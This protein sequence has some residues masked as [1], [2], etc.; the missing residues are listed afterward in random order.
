[1]VIEARINET[2][3]LHNEDG[4][5]REAS[6][7]L[8]VAGRSCPSLYSSAMVGIEVSWTGADILQ[9]GRVGI[10]CSL[11][12]VNKT[13]H[14]VVLLCDHVSEASRP[15]PPCI[16]ISNVHLAL[17]AN[18]SHAPFSFALSCSFSSSFSLFFSLAIESLSIINRH[19]LL[20]LL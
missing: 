14:C 3:E 13:S 10:G 1:M 17:G 7:G 8:S 16:R 6:V 18:P 2:L 11:S 5:G 15:V 4:E 12:V 9:L 19:S 20:I